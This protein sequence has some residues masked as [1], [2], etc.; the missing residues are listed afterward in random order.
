MAAV[1]YLAFVMRVWRPPM[2]GIWWSLSLCK[3]WLE[4]MQ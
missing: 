3:V 1:G 4:S 2:K